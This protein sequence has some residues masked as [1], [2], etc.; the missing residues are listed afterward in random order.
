MLPH[1]EHV[2]HI[3]RDSTLIKE[4]IGATVPGLLQDHGQHLVLHQPVDLN[5]DR[6]RGRPGRL[7]R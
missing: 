1:V 4:T 6:W 2:L 7:V 3:P 5:L